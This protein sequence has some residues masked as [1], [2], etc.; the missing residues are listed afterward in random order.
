MVAGMNATESAVIVTVPPA[1]EVVGKHRAELDQAAGWGVPAHVT[2]VYPFMPPADL[3]DRVIETL[4]RA[5]ATV[6]RFEATWSK[7]GW[8]G[9]DVLWLAPEP[10]DRFNA[11]TEAVVK[12]FPDFPP[13]GGEH[14][15]VIPHLTV[16]HGV[17]ADVLRDVEQ[18][19]LPHLPIGMQVTSAALWWGSPSAGSWRRVA[20]LPL[21]VPGT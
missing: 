8:F 21:G 7:T 11:L 13:Y 12:A 5:I 6:P 16:G 20:E 15:V 3:G 4:A 1:E 10:A 9:T 2:V 19:L 17:D 18:H 14:D